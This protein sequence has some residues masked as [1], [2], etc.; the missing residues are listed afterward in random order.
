MNLEE[1][2]KPH[3]VDCHL[4]K[5]DK[6]KL[7]SIIMKSYIDQSLETWKDKPLFAVKAENGDIYGPGTLPMKLDGI[8]NI[9]A[10]Y[11]LKVEKMV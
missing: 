7:I 11:L 5:I 3:E 2:T 9:E 6:W 4:I 8:P 1:H 10:T